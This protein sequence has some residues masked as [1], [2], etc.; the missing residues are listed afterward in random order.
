MITISTL[1]PLLESSPNPDPSL[2]PEPVIRKKMS[3]KQKRWLE[4][5][6]LHGNATRAAREAGYSCSNPRSFQ[7]IARENLR[8]LGCWTV[9]NEELRRE[10]SSILTKDEVLENLSGLALKAKKDADKIRA[11]ELMGKYHTLFKDYQVTESLD[12]KKETPE[13]LTKRFQEEV[14]R[15][16]QAEIPVTDDKPLI[17]T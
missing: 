12:D 7:Q 6:S 10:T 3:L 13:E 9:K 2:K 16:K 15:R 4:N 14:E 11:S 8:R 5:Y 1:E 17:T